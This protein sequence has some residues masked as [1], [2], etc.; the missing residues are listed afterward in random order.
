MSADE[1]AEAPSDAESDAEAPTEAP[2]G[3]EKVSGA[4]KKRLVKQ[5]LERLLVAAA[6]AGLSAGKPLPNTSTIRSKEKVEAAALGS[7][8][9]LVLEIFQCKTYLQPYVVGQPHHPLA[10]R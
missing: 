7:L 1:G 5:L 8:V 2:I 10:R 4:S 9:G 3:L 6:D